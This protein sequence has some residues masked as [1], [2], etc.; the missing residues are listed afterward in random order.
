MAHLQVYHMIEVQLTSREFC[1]ISKALNSLETDDG[2]PLPAA[3]KLRDDLTRS[4]ANQTIQ[5]AKPAHQVL[6]KLPPKHHDY[7]DLD[8]TE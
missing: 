4:R 2:A 1:L 7:G 3:Q 8:F 6:E 5:I